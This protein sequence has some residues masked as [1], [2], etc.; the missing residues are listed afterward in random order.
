M[1]H[2]LFYPYLQKGLYLLFSA[3]LLA[4][5]V[6]SANPVRQAS[7]ANA[8]IRPTYTITVEALID[9]RSQLILW[10]NKAQWHHFDFAAPGRHEFVNV[11][12]LINGKEWFPVWPDVP[13]AENRD[14]QCYSSI[15]K[16]VKPGLHGSNLQFEVTVL[17]GRGP[18]S[19]LEYPS[20]ENK[21]ALVIEFNDN[22]YDGS[23]VYEIQ[24]TFQIL[25]HRSQ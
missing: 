8:N 5:S 11:P 6:V 1:N 24:I 22:D 20:K 16:H 13:D 3:A 21:R 15:F 10:R 9:G 23:M 4:A 17:Q 7:A 2:K 12:T 18:V 14:C 25:P 19:V